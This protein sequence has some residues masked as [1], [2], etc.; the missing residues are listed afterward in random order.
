MMN[1]Q[2]RIVNLHAG[3]VAAVVDIDYAPTGKEFCTASY[4]K[5]IRIFRV[6]EVN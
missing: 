3:H 1:D 6:E 5:S 4:D 2:R